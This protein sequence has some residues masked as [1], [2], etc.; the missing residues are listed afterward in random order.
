MMEQLI[1]SDQLSE[2]LGISKRTL[3]RW[4]VEL[5]LPHYKIGRTVK[6]KPS[7][8]LAWLEQFRKGQ[9]LLIGDETYEEA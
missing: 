3:K 5:D 7:E 1:S 2:Q 4:L 9:N 8:I 6:F